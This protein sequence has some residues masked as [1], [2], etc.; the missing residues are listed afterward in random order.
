VL[1]VFEHGIIN[2]GTLRSPAL[3]I[4]FRC[5]KADL[6]RAGDMADLEGEGGLADLERAEGPLIPPFA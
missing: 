4:D 2:R 5:N 3:E 6:E 1:L